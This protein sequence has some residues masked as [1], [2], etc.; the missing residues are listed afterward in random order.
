MLPAPIQYLETELISLAHMLQYKKWVEDVSTKARPAMCSFKN[1]RA[2]HRFP[3]NY[4][5]IEL[6]VMT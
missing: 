4:T 6:V 2:W 5:W 1:T 3:C